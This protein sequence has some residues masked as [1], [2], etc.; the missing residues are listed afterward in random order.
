MKEK[1]TPPVKKAG[2]NAKIKNA[3][4]HSTISTPGQPDPFRVWGPGVGSNKKI[5]G[6]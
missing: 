6:K 5:M 4:G 1:V 2:K 3:P